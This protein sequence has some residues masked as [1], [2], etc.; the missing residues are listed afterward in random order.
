MDAVSARFGT[1]VIGLVLARMMSPRDFGAFGVV[2]V[3]LLGVQSVGQLGAGSALAIWRGSPDE[4][5][6]TV[7]AI[8]F[9]SSAA[10]YAACYA[11]APAFAATMGAPAAAHVIRLVALNVMISG[12]VAAPRG[13]LQRR[14]PR[15][16]V[17][18]VQVD[19][20]L[21]VLVTIG[22]FITG[23][24][25]MSLAIGRIAGGLA[26]A[27]IVTA[28]SPR[29]LR[30]GFNRAEAGA[31]LEIALPFAASSA[32]AFGIT[33]A[34]QIVVG[35]ILHARDLGFYLLALCV[36][37]W[38]ATLFSQPVR[39]AA[40]VAFAR[41]RRGPQVV[42][43]AFMSSANLL[44]SMTL[45]ACIL[46]SC[47]ARPLI[48]VVYGPAWAPAAHV[49]VW[50]APL[51]TL[52]VFYA[53]ASDYFAVLASSR[54]ALTFQ[55]I[56]LVTLVPSLVAGAW[57]HGTLGVAV[58]QVIIAVLLLLP[59][60]LT[61]LK[62]LAIWPRA[63]VARL[64]FPIGAAA[65]VGL[66]AVGAERLFPDSQLDV[67]IGGRR[68]ARRH[69]P[70]RVQDAQSVRGGTE[71]RCGRGGRIRAGGRRHR[72]GPRV[73]VRT[74]PG[75]SGHPDGAHPA[76]GPRGGAPG[77]GRQ[78]PRRRPLEPDKYRRPA[79]QQLL[80]R[81]AAGPDR[82]RPVGVGPVRG[83]ADCPHGPAERE[84]AGGQRGDHPLGRRCPRLR[85]D[86]LYPVRGVE[87]GHLRGAVGNRPLP[88]PSARLA[89]PRPPWCA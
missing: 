46:I 61:E 32:L 23:H 24:G 36:A 16:S 30:I 55:L 20:W 48:Q 9:A 69:G 74:G 72:A 54:R 28:F 78:D 5:V 87:H 64:S 3:A 21:G 17:M 80:R 68:R 13:M 62:P 29:S 49:L 11:G 1:L 19:N 34:D 70:A 39:D 75:L 79:G 81:G 6:P 76:P 53:L 47:T 7:T 52:R 84:R 40:P 26:A 35:H 38:P 37:T 63:P 59:W 82:V 67:A 33:N 14:A 44:A 43:S 57:K 83:F 42:G 60:Y 71:S 73:S 12:V 85:T 66:I 89:R 8:S 25:L 15:L 86:R 22:L 51:A 58:V 50:L 4:I 41:F 2:V 31:L 56:W 65:A 18:V 27:I 88:R 45:P 10:V 77:P